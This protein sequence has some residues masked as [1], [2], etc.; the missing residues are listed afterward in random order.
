VDLPVELRTELEKNKLTDSI[1]SLAY[2]KRKE[3][4]RQ[5]A[6]AKSA[7][8]VERRVEKIINGLRGPVS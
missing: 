6:E 8:T 7:E 1:N 4:A 2:S 3:F 5:V